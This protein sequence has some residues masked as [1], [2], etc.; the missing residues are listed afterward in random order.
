MP[1]GLEVRCFW[2]GLAEPASEVGRRLGG[3]RLDRLAGRF[4]PR[5]SSIVERRAQPR[6]AA[7]LLG[8]IRL[9]RFGF[10]PER[11]SRTVSA[12]LSC[13]DAGVRP[14]GLCKPPTSSGTGA[15]ST[16]SQSRAGKTSSSSRRRLSAA[17]IRLWSAARR[18]R[19]VPPRTVPPVVGS[20]SRGAIPSARATRASIVSVRS[21]PPGA[22]D[23]AEAA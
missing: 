3:R 16:N 17:A 8:I 20:R 11:I 10:G 14:F 6:P 2:S 4:G 21:D 15:T 12:L 13:A 19:S 5:Y 9:F 22:G 18:S 7:A 23:G 1:D